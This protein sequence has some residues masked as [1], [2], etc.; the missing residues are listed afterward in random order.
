MIAT[1]DLILMWYL[2]T[3]FITAALAPRPEKKDGGGGG[4]AACLEARV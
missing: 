1:I 2:V 3:V 4:K